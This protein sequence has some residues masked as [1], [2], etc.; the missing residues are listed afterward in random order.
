MKL[1]TKEKEYVGDYMATDSGHEGFNVMGASHTIAGYMTVIMRNII[2][3][4]N[5]QFTV[6]DIGRLTLLIAQEPFTWFGL[7]TSAL[8]SSD[9][10]GFDEKTRI[11]KV[12]MS[13]WELVFKRKKYNEKQ[14]KL[15]GDAFM[16][17]LQNCEFIS[18]KQV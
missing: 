15:S 3:H 10:E 8:Y 5:E 2:E 11:G 6:Y 16:V 4:C 12:E 13:G 17:F 7:Q 18:L 1:T 14:F 9:S